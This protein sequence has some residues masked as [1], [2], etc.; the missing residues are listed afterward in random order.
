MARGRLVTKKQR[1]QLP[2][3]DSVDD[4]K[5]RQTLILM[6]DRFDEIARKKIIKTYNDK[7]LLQKYHKL[8]MNDDGRAYGKARRRPLAEFPNAQVFDF[9]D[10][11]MTGLYGV[12][13]LQQNKPFKHELIKP[14]LIAKSV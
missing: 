1:E 11:V 8:R 3:F 9:V 2:N 7:K 12:D 4:K 6:T 10:T 13:W 14:W 5:L